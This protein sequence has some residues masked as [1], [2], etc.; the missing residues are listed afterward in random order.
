MWRE[1]QHPPVGKF[2]E[3]C[4]GYFFHSGNM[5][6]SLRTIY[7]AF[8]EVFWCN[9]NDNEKVALPR[10]ISKIKNDLGWTPKEDFISG[11]RKTVKWYLDNLSWSRNIED[12]SYRLERLGVDLK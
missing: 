6:I 4:K 9:N 10:D 8:L 2:C 1:S 11:I 7:G 12:G 3:I 5:K